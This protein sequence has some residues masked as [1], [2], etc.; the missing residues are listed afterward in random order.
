MRNKWKTLSP[1][2]SNITNSEDRIGFNYVI[3]NGHHC[4]RD[5]YGLLWLQA[6]TKLNRIIWAKVNAFLRY[7]QLNNKFEA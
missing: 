1:K 7:M 3:N 5:A 4:Y 2:L 6:Q